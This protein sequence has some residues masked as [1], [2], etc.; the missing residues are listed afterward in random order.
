[1]ELWLYVGVVD[2]DGGG[3]FSLEFAADEGAVVGEDGDDGAGGEAE[4]FAEFVDLL[5]GKLDLAGGVGARDEEPG[6]GP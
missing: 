6:E 4:D 2:V 3:R 1:M 5:A